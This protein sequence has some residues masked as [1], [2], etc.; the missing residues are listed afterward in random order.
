MRPCPSGLEEVENYGGE[1]I[2]CIERNSPFEVRQVLTS[3][4]STSCGQRDWMTDN[5]GLLWFCDEDCK[6]SWQAQQKAAKKA[7]ADAAAAAKAAAR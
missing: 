2:A 1:P 4:A 3:C 6:K 5:K 7:K